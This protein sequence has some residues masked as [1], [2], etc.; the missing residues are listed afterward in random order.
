VKIGVIW[1]GYQCADQI[2]RSLGPWVRAK[3]DKLGGHEFVICAVSV[4]FK[5]F[6]QPPQLDSTVR[7]LQSHAIDKNIDYLVA[8]AV[9]LTEVEA[10]GRALMWLV[11]QEVDVC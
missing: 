4:P 7:T 5:G 9:P 2:D 11:D 3:L 6:E 8:S 10:R 1:V